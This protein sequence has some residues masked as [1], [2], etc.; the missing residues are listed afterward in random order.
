MLNSAA[1]GRSKSRIELP[2]RGRGPQPFNGPFPRSARASAEGSLHETNRAPSSASQ[3]VI[4]L[5]GIVGKLNE[6]MMRQDSL[7]AAAQL[8][9]YRR[10]QGPEFQTFGQSK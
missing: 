4:P 5:T 7:Q 8:P 10:T 1:I 9:Q 2:S 6:T 3:L